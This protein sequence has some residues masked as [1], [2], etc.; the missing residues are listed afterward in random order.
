MAIIKSTRSKILKNLFEY[1]EDSNKCN[2]DFCREFLPHD[3]EKQD[4]DSNL[5][6]CL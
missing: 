2:N 4:I 3:Y 6:F 1:L 5:N